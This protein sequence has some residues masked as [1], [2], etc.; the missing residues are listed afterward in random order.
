LFIF[1]YPILILPWYH[2]FSLTTERAKNDSP[3][4]IKEILEKKSDSED[5]NTT[6]LHPL[7]DSRDDIE[8]LFSKR[9]RQSSKTRKKI[10]NKRDV[11]SNSNSSALDT[12]YS[13]QAPIDNIRHKIYTDSSSSLMS[14]ISNKIRKSSSISTS[15]VLS[16]KKNVS[17]RKGRKKQNVQTSSNAFNKYFNTNSIHESTSELTICPISN[18]IR[19]ISDKRLRMFADSAH[20]AVQML[21]ES[22]DYKKTHN[23]ARMKME[24]VLMSYGICVN[25]LSL[26][27]SL[28]AAMLL[29]EAIKGLQE[30]KDI[31]DVESLSLN[32]WETIILESANFVIKKKTRVISPEINQDEN[33]TVP[34]KALLDSK[35]TRDNTIALAAINVIVL[36]LIQ[37][38]DD[39]GEITNVK[40]KNSA[41]KH[42]LSSSSIISFQ[43]P[44]QTCGMNE[45]DLEKKQIECDSKEQ[46]NFVSFDTQKKEHCEL[47]QSLDSNNLD[48]ILRQK[49][50][51]ND[52]KQSHT[53][54][55]TWPLICQNDMA[56]SD[57]RRKSA[58]AEKLQKR[59]G[60]YKF[61]NRKDKHV[62]CSLKRKDDKNEKKRENLIGNFSDIA[63]F[64]NEKIEYISSYLKAKS[65]LSV[66]LQKNEE[67]N[68]KVKK[69]VPVPILKKNTEMRKISARNKT[70]IHKRE[71]TSAESM[72]AAPE[73]RSYFSATVSLNRDRKS[74]NNGDMNITSASASRTYHIGGTNTQ[75]STFSHEMNQSKQIDQTVF[76]SSSRPTPRA[77]VQWLSS[78]CLVK[79]MKDEIEVFTLNS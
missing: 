43:H 48:T 20:A 17:V 40:D 29:I 49:Q 78:N 59:H 57:I 71:K 68:M 10:K 33:K 47:T 61:G 30:S 2:S 14:S 39:A 69:Q 27:Q 4:I 53:S 76:Y 32:R 18:K 58:F 15:S 8:S 9:K 1:F 62:T 55:V 36:V 52:T 72:K 67:S 13:S 34:L 16:R 54:F 42:M 46:Q 79:I 3:L 60:T 50:N 45:S 66:V 65:S 73:E 64:L 63:N 37:T 41:V 11:I 51:D 77:D 22:N 31:I 25:E 7:H 26:N 75:S 21:M 6:S 44:N 38:F 74:Q 35:S 28:R 19:A 12:N 5:L 70:Q 24:K 56:I 23:K